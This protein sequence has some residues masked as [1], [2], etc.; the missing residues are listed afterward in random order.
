MDRNPSHVPQLIEARRAIPEVQG[1]LVAL[2]GHLDEYQAKLKSSHDDLA[3]LRIT[4]RY[5]ASSHY[6]IDHDSANHWQVRVNELISRKTA[7]VKAL[8]VV[9]QKAQEAII[10]LQDMNHQVGLAS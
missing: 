1:Q 8:E 10:I 2:K 6:H 7:D 5:G 3:C 9:A 4:L